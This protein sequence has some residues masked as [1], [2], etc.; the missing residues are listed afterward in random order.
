M[1]HLT[2]QSA[3]LAPLEQ[4]WAFH[5]DPNNLMVITPPWIDIVP[6]DLP[7]ETVEN[8][9]ARIGIRR[10]GLTLKWTML[11]EKVEPPHRFVDRALHSPFA[12]FRHTHRF[13]VFREGSRME[14]TLICDTVEFKLP[15]GPLG[16]LFEPLVLRELRRMFAY[17]H[18]ATKNALEPIFA[19]EN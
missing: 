6:F 12:Y 5:A 7:R 8:Q 1:R 17:R 19:A 11:F 10:F 15:F 16:K 2:A 3:V 13:Q 14:G 4:V 9:T 18:E